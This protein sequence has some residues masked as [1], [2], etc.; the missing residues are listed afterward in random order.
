MNTDYGIQ[1]L[2]KTKP[3]KMKKFIFIPI[4]SALSCIIFGQA[5]VTVTVT[6]GSTTLN[7]DCDLFGDSDNLWA[8]SVQDGPDVDGNGFPLSFQ[9]EQLNGTS[10][11]APNVPAQIFS[12]MYNACIPNMLLFEWKGCED[13]G[14][15][16]FTNCDSD[17]QGTNG[18]QNEMIPLAPGTTTFNG[19]G[20]NGPGGTSCAEA[21]YSITVSVTVDGAPSLPTVPDN[22]CDAPLLTADCSVTEWAW[23]GDQTYE[24]DE[25]VLDPPGQIYDPG[26]LNMS[27]GGTAWF[28]FTMPAGAI[29]ITTDPNGNT[30]I[31]TEF[32]IYHAVDG[33]G[34]D[35]FVACNPQ[36]Y[37]KYAYLNAQDGAFADLGGPLSTSSQADLELDCN[38]L[39]AGANGLIPGE[40][41]YIAVSSD[42]ANELGQL[43]IA[44]CSEDTELT[45]NRPTYDIPCGAIDATAN[46]ASTTI[47]D[48]ATTTE[49]FSIDRGCA[50]DDEII[51]DDPHVYDLTGVDPNGDIAESSVWISFVA[52]ASGQV[53]IEANM[54]LQGEQMALFEYDPAF[55]PGTDATL[56]C[57]N[58]TAIA[59]S[60]GGALG[61]DIAEIDA[62]CLEPGYTYY[63]VFDEPTVAAG[64]MNV[65]IYDQSVAYPGGHPP[66]VDAARCDQLGT[67]IV[68]PGNDNMCLALADASYEVPVNAI[69][70]CGALSL[71]GDNSNACIEKFAGEPINGGGMTTWHYFTVPNSG[72]VEINLTANTALNYNVY[73]TFDG[74]TAGC[75]G[76]LASR[77]YES[78]TGSCELNP[79][80]NGCSTCGPTTKCCLTPGEVLAI[81]VDAAGAAA[82]GP[83]T[84]EINEIEVTAGE[85]SYVD[86]DGETVTN[87]TTDP[88]AE[89]PAIFCNGEVLTPSSSA[90]ECPPT[91]Y[92]VAETSCDYPGCMTIGY[93]IH[94]SPTAPTDISAI[95]IYESDAPGG[96][97]GYINDGSTSIPTC[98]VVYLSPLVDGN[99]A[100]NTWGDICPSAVMGEPAPVVFLTEMTATPVAPVAG[101][102]CSITFD[103]SGGMPCFDGSDYLFTVAGTDISGTSTGGTISFI[104]TSNA[105]PLMVTV[106]DSEGCSIEVAVDASACVVTSCTITNGTWSKG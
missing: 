60:D 39:L 15:L 100:D 94:N 9:Y 50:F 31:G 66:C 53:S 104:S 73:N 51:V 90:T 93:A 16:G 17:G 63:V 58:L 1:S 49:D 43:D 99:N 52:P 19:F 46:A 76:G 62:S 45:S 4:F 95:T 68:G 54:S 25:L 28:A 72:S 27:V 98:S 79:C 48:N 22:I 6:G 14:G 23:C 64:N 56:S 26:V 103:I 101:A 65:W 75:Y 81:Q 96:T 47:S 35:G 7:A 88:A 89:G 18:T 42:D 13:D 29:S 57:A 84:L 36:P 34:C 80:V 33:Y 59:F 21:D 3:T 67:G 70:S 44:I 77:I 41:Y 82:A 37:S 87:A 91:S 92:C 2:S 38:D 83:Y 85:I 30:Q 55:A 106:T 69:G 8:I 71:D 74:T 61:N 11:S 97:A 5:T 40:V 24:A 12:E 105:N 10:Q 20:T 78:T 32:V 86:P 102:D